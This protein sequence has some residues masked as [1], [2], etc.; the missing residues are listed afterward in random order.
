MHNKWT[1]SIVVA[2]IL[3]IFCLT[4]VFAKDQMK[5][6]GAEVTYSNEELK[7]FIIANAGL[8]QLQQ[9]AVAQIQS[10]ESDQQKR[11]VMETTNQQML[12]VL[13]QTGLTADKYNAMGQTIQSDT[14]LQEKVQTIASDLFQ[15]EAQQ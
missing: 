3:G 2:F 14:Q 12:L 8:Y 5:T 10:M 1:I 4:P 9:Q 6:E 13:E 7:S 15:Q 11:E